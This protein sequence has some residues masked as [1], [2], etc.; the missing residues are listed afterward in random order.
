MKTFLPFIFASFVLINP[1]MAEEGRPITISSSRLSDDERIVKNF[2]GVAAG[3][4]I[5]VVIKFGDKESIRFEGDQE[6]ISTLISEVRGSILIIRPQ[7]SW[8][9]WAKKYENKKITAYVTAKQIS[10]ITMSGDG[11][12][13]V[14]GTI[15]AA[16]F[17]TTL[18]GSGAIKANVEADKITGVL[19]G[20]GSL[21]LTG[22]AEEASVTLSGSGSFGSKSLAINSI[23]TRISGSGNVNVQSNGKIKAVISGSGHVYY[24][25]NAEVNE[26]VLIGSGRVSKQ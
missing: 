25:G 20:S 3:G 11:T 22:K 1:I 13:T 8:K 15:T 2:N 6:A 7:N 5:D 18:S 9:S 10:S 24:S 4:P 12:I 16:E 21:N 26:T 23:S 17:A 19:S 14:N